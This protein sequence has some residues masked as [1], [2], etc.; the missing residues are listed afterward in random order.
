MRLFIAIDYETIN[1]YL[2]NIQQELKTDNAK[3]R[4]T[5]SFHLTLKFLENAE[6][7]PV[8]KALEKITFE[9]LRIIIVACLGIIIGISVAQGYSAVVP[10]SII[11]ATVLINYLFHHVN[12]IVADERDYKIA[13][14]G[15]LATI[16]IVSITLVIVGATMMAVGVNYPE[17][18]KIGYLFLYIVCFIMITK[19]ITFQI[20]QKR[21]DK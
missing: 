7:E 8:I 1:S 19:I 15:S 5:D 11:V 9:K 18:K 13:G 16:N 10:I 2:K 6:P 17:F 14:K 20:Y 4:F 12:E 21:G 3:V